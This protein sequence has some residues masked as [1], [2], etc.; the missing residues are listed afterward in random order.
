MKA[1]NQTQIAK[2]LSLTP[3][4]I[5]ELG[6]EGLPSDKHGRERTYDPPAAVAWYV[7][8]RERLAR[9]AAESPDLQKARAR[10]RSAKASMAELELAER[11]GSLVPIGYIEDILGPA[12]TLVRARINR[13]PGTWPPRLAPLEDPRAVQRELKELANELL[14]DLAGVADDLEADA[15]S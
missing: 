10:E 14:E 6:K 15:G 1:L 8:Y 4:R 11:V 3:Q 7:A 12:L 13:I 2:L 5:R 9:E